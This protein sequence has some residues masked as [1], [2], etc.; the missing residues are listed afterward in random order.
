MGSLANWPRIQSYFTHSIPIDGPY[1]QL[2]LTS[3]QKTDEDHGDGKR[4]DLG[5]V[6]STGTGVG[7]R[8]RRELGRSSRSTG[9]GVEICGRR[10]LVSKF[11]DACTSSDEGHGNGRRSDRGG[12]RVLV[13]R[14]A[15][16]ADRGTGV[17]GRGRLHAISNG[18]R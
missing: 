6:G 8:D 1:G 18:R 3:I 9:T 5:W 4:S 10:E 17:E 16:R 14:F 2:S 12:Q 13:S 11:V 15:D 7:V